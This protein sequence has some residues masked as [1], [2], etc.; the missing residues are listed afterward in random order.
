MADDDSEDKGEEEA[1]APP[2]ANG[3]KMVMVVGAVTFLAVLAAH[4]AAPIVGGMIFG[5]DEAA[6]EAVTDDEEMA[7][8]PDF[9]ELDPAIYVPLDPP[10]L[11]S[12]EDSSG[13]T[14]YLQ[15]SIQAMGRDQGEMDAVR[16]HAPAIRNA[17]LFLMSNF[18]YED[19]STP[20]GIERL[21]TEMLAEAQGIMKHNTGE[22]GVEEIYF[23]SLVVQ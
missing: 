11:G 14:R 1:P 22:P 19:V 10:M 20:E 15:M 17:F 8:E 23:T 21:R 16:N 4:V 2:Q 5:S 7:E 9:T 12:F 18:S 3:K 13:E 6:D